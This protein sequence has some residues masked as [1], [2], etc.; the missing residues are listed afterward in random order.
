MLN[1]FK[2]KRGFT[3]VELVVVIL[4]LGVLVAIAVPIY[5]SV[6]E[7]SKLKVCTAI[8]KEI[9]TNIKNYCID[10][11]YNENYTFKI[12]SNAEEEKGVL[13]DKD[14]NELKEEADLKLVKEGFLKNDIPYCPSNGTYTVVVT[15]VVGGIAKIEVSCDGNEDTH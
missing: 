1:F 6:N 2:S 11:N 7:K 10:N 13:L 9:Y 8:Q 14:G 4:I 15:K 3:L 12:R 5:S